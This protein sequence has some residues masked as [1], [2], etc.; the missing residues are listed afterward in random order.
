MGSGMRGEWVRDSLKG[1]APAMMSTI[2]LYRSAA[3]D[4]EDL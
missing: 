3:I 4:P 2:H 1:V